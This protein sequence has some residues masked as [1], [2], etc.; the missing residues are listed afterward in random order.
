[1]DEVAIR[2]GVDAAADILETEAQRQ[3]GLREDLFGDGDG[4][5][6]KAASDLALSYRTAAAFLRKRL[7][8]QPRRR[9]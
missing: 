9:T 5:G 2:A 4:A 1:M 7:T 3:L 8:C 6:A